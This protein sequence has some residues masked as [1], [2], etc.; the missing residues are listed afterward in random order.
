MHV[1]HPTTFFFPYDTKR[2]FYHLTS[3]K[4]LNKLKKFWYTNHTPGR[5]VFTSSLLSITCSLLLHYFGFAWLRHQCT[6]ANQTD[7][8]VRFQIPHV[9][10]PR[11]F[12]SSLLGSSLLFTRPD[13]D[14]FQ[15][16]FSSVTQPYLFDHLSTNPCVTQRRP[17]TNLDYDFKFSALMA[18]KTKASRPTTNNKPTSVH[19]VREV[20]NTQIILPSTPHVTHQVHPAQR[21]LCTQEEDNAQHP[22]H[23]KPCTTPPFRPF[24]VSGLGECHCLTNHWSSLSET[25]PQRFALIQNTD[26]GVGESSG[27]MWVNSV[28]T[29]TIWLRQKTSENCQS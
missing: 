18:P 6:F 21:T 12:G 22:T 17:P 4:K 29:K 13:H 23:R 9:T 1:C 11:V 2:P 15:I 14:C 19:L 5:P 16:S 10:H 28:H 27:L 25:K 24:C 20:D 26:T 7:H 8:T 3:R